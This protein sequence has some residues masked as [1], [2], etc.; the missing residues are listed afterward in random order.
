M[1]ESTRGNYPEQ[2]GKEAIALGMVPVGGLFV[3]KHYPKI[4]WEEIRGLT[5]PELAQLIFQS[6]LPDFEKEKCIEASEIYNNKVFD[7]DN[8]A[9]LVR[10]GKMGILE[11]WHGPTAAFKDM[12]LQVLPHLLGE[13]MKVLTKTDRVLILVATSGDTGKAALEGFKNVKGT[14][15]MVFYPEHGVS[16]VQERQMTTTDGVNTRVV[17]VMGNFDQCQSAV[18]EIFA[19]SKLR[20]TFNQQGIAFS[21]ANS[22][23]WGR[24]LPQIV[25][26]FWAY[27]QSVESQALRPGEEMNVVVPTGNFGNILAAYYAKI[28]GL[29]INK[30]I[31]ASNENNVL[32]DFFAEGIYNRNRPFYVT[33]SPSMD[34]LISSNFERFLYE[35]SGRRPDKISK[36]YK[37]LQERGAFKVDSDTLAKARDAVVAGWANEEEVLKVID[38]VYQEYSYVL[39]PHTAVAVKVYDDYAKKTGDQTY[40]IIASTASPYKFAKTVLAGI[41][42]SAVSGDEWINLKK[43]SEITGWAIPQGLQGLEDKQTFGMSQVSPDK[44]SELI[45]KVYI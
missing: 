22:I 40:T 5:Y 30:L 41:D 19:S 12:A 28:M 4:N 9:P 1:Y 14:E 32:T 8:P 15:I 6:Y 21:S 16:T 44:I 43:L 45:K 17:P 23:N 26:Y 37:D 2:T 13:S 24:L 27:L 36:W 33:S 34:I 11:L 35:M 7:S 31:C 39:D 20:A 10:V 42:A 38:A 29:P 25:Y 18:K 3:P